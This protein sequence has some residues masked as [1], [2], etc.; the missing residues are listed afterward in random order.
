MP[1]I[2]LEERE[3]F[4]LERKKEQ[5]K[6]CGLAKSQAASPVSSSYNELLKGSSETL[7]QAE[8][9]YLPFCC[10]GISGFTLM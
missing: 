5:L 1:V 2:H 6:V 3:C 8:G 4:F 7:S 10:I 9:A